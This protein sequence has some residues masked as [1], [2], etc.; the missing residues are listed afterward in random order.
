MKSFILAGLLAASAMAAAVKPRIAPQVVTGPQGQDMI[1]HGAGDQGDGAYLA[2]FD[3]N[4]E[5]TVEFTPY[6][7]LNITE[8]HFNEYR[9][10][11]EW[12]MRKRNPFQPVCSGDGYAP[13]ND[14]ANIQL[15]HNADGRRYNSVA[16]GWAFYGNAV[17]YFCVY[18]GNLD[19]FYSYI[20]DRCIELSNWC[21]GSQKYGYTQCTPSA[22]ND[23]GVGCP[24]GIRY[25]QG[26][27]FRGNNFC[28][29]SF[30]G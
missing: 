8:E 14:G 17:A 15:A 18:Q 30:R 3:E 29:G 10:R 7:D 21:G 1:I 5:A 11:S 9:K 28:D 6:A 12:A 4:N 2:V 27:T 26:R 22:A 19:L 25:N 20:I 16:Y 13:D 24:L 23:Q